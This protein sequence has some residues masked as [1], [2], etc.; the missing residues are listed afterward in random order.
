MDSSILYATGNFFNLNIMNQYF[1]NLP[2]LYS[3]YT[4]QMYNIS[5]DNFLRK[6]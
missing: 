2:V 4:Q 5:T 1:S 3:L 6:A